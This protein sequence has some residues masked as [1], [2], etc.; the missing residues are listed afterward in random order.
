MN[1]VKA[2]LM[3]FAVV[4]LFGNWSW[5]AAP[6]NGLVAEYLFEGNA[7][8]T[9]GN[10]NNGTVHGA[11]LI[12]DRFGRVNGAYSFNGVNAYISV[13]DRA[14]FDLTGDYAFSVWIYQKS[15]TPSWT[16]RI[17]DKATAATCDGWNLDTWD[18]STGRGIRLDVGCPWTIADSAHSLNA[19]HHVVA[20]VKGGY[21]T[22]YLDGQIDGGGTVAST[23]TNSLDVYIGAG[24]GNSSI[25]FDGAIDDI[26]IYNRALSVPEVAALYN[27]KEPVITSLTAFPSAGSAPLDVN[28]TCRATSPNGTIIQYFWDVNGD[29]VTDG[30]T[31]TGSFSYTYGING[32]YKTRV[33]AVDSAGY[34]SGFGY[35]RVKVGDGPEL[36]GRVEYYQ[37]D[38][39]AKTFEMKIR[40][41]NWGNAAASPFN[42]IFSASDNGKGSKTFRTVPVPGGLAAGKDT[43][44]NASHTFTES[45]YGRLISVVIDGGKVVAEVDE[46]NN[47]LQ[48]YIGPTPK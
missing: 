7:K 31:G 17:L 14:D 42:V 13:P 2:F 37:F 3:V 35:V 21:V 11:V 18:G 26:R 30:V 32:T 48:L 9:S 44:L 46:T 29:G 36:A 12:R 38:D 43:L 40:L 20:T 24:H 39:T 16:V 1:N 25:F 22:F 47:S 23:P 28:F 10:G 15:A 8:D 45:I 27:D 34:K 41:Y 19:W 5:A 4:F 6:K 33:R